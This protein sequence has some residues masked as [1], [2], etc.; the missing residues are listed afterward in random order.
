M[1]S[2]RSLLAAF[3]GVAAC[4]SLPAWAAREPRHTIYFN[5][6]VLNF[7]ILNM[8]YYAAMARDNF[9]ARRG[10]LGTIRYW[11]AKP[12]ADKRLINHYWQ[13]ERSAEDAALWRLRRD[14]G[15]EEN[16]KTI[17]WHYPTE[18][19]HPDAEKWR[20]RY[21]DGWPGADSRLNRTVWAS[22][23]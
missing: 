18:T 2:R 6:E 15:R 22:P 1:I 10:D 9:V 23:V 17:G 3:G 7:P 16:I 21:R 8:G 5:V 12:N 20:Q 13:C 19:F 14:E 4:I 11:G